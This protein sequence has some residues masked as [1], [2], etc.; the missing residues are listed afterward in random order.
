MTNHEKMYHP[1]V[2]EYSQ[3]GDAHWYANIPTDKEEGPFI[4]F[5]AFGTKPTREQ[6]DHLRLIMNKI[7]ALIAESDLCNIPEDRD[8]DPAW[9][10]YNLRCA[11]VTWVTLNE[12]GSSWVG[13]EGIDDGDGYYLA[14]LLNI[15]NNFQLIS[16][17][18]A[19]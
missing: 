7:P 11:Q 8:T 3:S 12:D 6:L 9:S 2:G 16:A 14:P 17:E 4:R 13:M 1:L 15:S 10:S 18:W 5:R 19:V